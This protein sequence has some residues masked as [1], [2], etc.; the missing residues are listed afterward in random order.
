MN[1]E[2]LLGPLPSDHTVSYM[3]DENGQEVEVFQ[4]V[5]SGKH[6]FEDPRLGPLP[7]AWARVVDHENLRGI[8]Y[9]SRETGEEQWNDPRLTVEKL[10]ERGVKVQQIVLE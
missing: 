6:N 9:K 3:V 4:Q 8:T 10:R 1:G 5:D 2:A 7:D